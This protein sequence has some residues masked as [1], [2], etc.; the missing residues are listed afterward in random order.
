MRARASAAHRVD[1]AHWARTR[2]GFVA[3]FLIL[4]LSGIFVYVLWTLRDLPD[5]GQQDVLANTVIVYDR[6][7]QVIE[8]RNAEGQFHDVLALKDMGKYGPEATLAAE[9]RDF[10]HH[11]AIDVPATI[12]AALA[13]LT[14]GSAQQGGSTISQQLIKIQ[15]LTPQKSIFRK[16]QEA[17]LATALEQR[18]SKDEI[19]NMYLNRVFYGHNA[20]GLGAATKTYFGRDKEPKDLTI[21]QAAFLAGL[22]NS[23]NYYDPQTHLDRAKARQAYVLNGMVARGDI[24]RAQADQAAQENIQAALRFDT[25]PRTSRAPHFV[26]YVMSKLEQQYGAAAVQQGGFAV[27]TTLDL[28][29]QDLADK[30]VKQGVANLK[31][32]GVNNGM[33]LAAKP[34]TGEILA[35]VGSADY[36]NDQIGGQFDVITSPR[37]PGSSFKPY[38]Y[39]AALK[40]HKITLATIVHDKSTDFGGGYKPLDF[41]NR[42]MGDMSARKALV[43]SRNVPAVEVAKNE[44]I[45]NVNNLAHAMGIRTDLQPVLSTAIGGSEVTMYDH[46]QGYEVFA[47]QGK[48]VPLMAIDKIVD[49]HGNTLYEQ[50]PGKQDG[51]TQVLSPAE[52]Y[53]ITDVLKDYQKQWNLGW[54]KQFASKSG[55]TGGSQTGVHKDAW[56]MA[57]NA[58]IVVGAWGGNT[59]NGGG[60]SSIST[61]GTEV[62]QTVLASF[63]NGLPPDYNGMPPRPSGIVDGSGCPGQDDTHEIFLA[64]TEK[65]SG[66]TPSSPSPSATP[67]TAPT[68]PPSTPL[69]TPIPTAIPTPVSTPTPKPSSSP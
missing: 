9:D 40:D 49:T 13:D 29:L 57:Y 33:L 36:Y 21:A 7:G 47:N 19:L 35:W 31:G 27:Y 37:Q 48:K 11:G 1:F 42:F 28:N 16:L 60:G 69:P 20:Y 52:A 26:D 30:A 58:K 68:P 23:P 65:G 67:S 50:Q 12:R 39:E 34:D 63:I 24:T 5:P 22:I 56:M 10:Y 18:Y 61:F 3:L 38:D 25:S 41:D 8:Q 55:T 6:S 15:L 44:G 59:A 43:L 2:G 17:V 14:S 66:C 46:L 53:L 51:Q 32:G 64:G 45:D 4:L 54:N 62:G